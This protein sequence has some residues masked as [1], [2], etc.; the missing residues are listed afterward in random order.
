VAGKAALFFKPKHLAPAV[1]PP[2]LER[3]VGALLKGMDYS[4]QAHRKITELVHSADRN[5]QFGYINEQVKVFQ[6]RQQ[7]I[8]SVDTKKKEWVGDFKN[9]E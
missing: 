1:P 2:R 6:A 3:K 7:P 4:L 9:H 5:A 8:I